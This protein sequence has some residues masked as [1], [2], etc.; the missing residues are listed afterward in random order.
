MTMEQA[1][2]RVHFDQVNPTNVYKR[3][4]KDYD[5]AMAQNNDDFYQA[6]PMS[7]LLK[8]ED[9]QSYLA[10]PLGEGKLEKSLELFHF[11]PLKDQFHIP[12]D[13][14]AY[15]EIKHKHPP[16]WIRPPFLPS[17]ASNGIDVG[18]EFSK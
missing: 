1:T 15:R 10:D 11:K 4:R 18:K 8:G 3:E 17:I 12:E 16:D 14:E 2:F 9:Y 13:S 6:F 7:E 5:Y